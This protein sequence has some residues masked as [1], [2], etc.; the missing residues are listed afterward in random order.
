MGGTIKFYTDE[1][2]SKAIIHGLRQRGI[3][4]LTTKEA[5]MLGATDEEP[6]TLAL[7]QGRVI[8]T[9]DEDFL[10]LHATGYQHKGIVYIHQHTSV[11]EII[12]GLVLVFQILEPADLVNQVEYL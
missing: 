4:V 10:K 3:G 8:F 5:G 2:V 11:G 12:R 9:H 1:H 7:Q 6:L